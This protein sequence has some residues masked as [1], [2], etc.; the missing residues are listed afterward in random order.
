MKSVFINRNEIL[1]MSNGIEQTGSFVWQLV[2][3]LFVAWVI[4]YMMV[5]NGI[6]VTSPLLFNLEQQRLKQVIREKVSGKLVYFTAIF[7][8]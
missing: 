5:I 1:Q 4:V 7:R 3:A 8:K 6:K 2:L